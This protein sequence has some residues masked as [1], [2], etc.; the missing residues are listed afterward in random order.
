MVS[1]EGV[2]VNEKLEDE[3]ELVNQDAEGAGWI[4]KVKVSDQS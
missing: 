3:P 4:M 2:E 1:G